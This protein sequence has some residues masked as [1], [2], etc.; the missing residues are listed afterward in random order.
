MTIF[1]KIRVDEIDSAVLIEN[2]EGYGRRI[3]NRFASAVSFCISGQITYHH[4]G[5]DYVS[6]PGTVIFLP[7]GESYTITCEKSGVFPVIN[8]TATLPF[9]NDTIYCMPLR[10]PEYFLLSFNK[11][12]S[13]FA[14]PDSGREVHAF[15][16]LYDILSH[17]ISDLEDKGNAVLAPAIKYLEDNFCDPDLNNSQL[18]DCCHISEVYFR[19]IFTAA[20]GIPP[21]KYISELRIQRAKELLKNNRLSI[22]QVSDSCGY[23]SVYHFCRAFK[24]AV[25]EAPGKY[26]RNSAMW[27]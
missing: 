9:K 25:G 6:K 10:N 7:Q 17:I 24:A 4:K 22:S 5:K 2:T 1:E 12:R 15:A 3:S 18:A 23:S 13:T 14:L 11:L 19:R 26:R 20:Y 27:F 16:Q 8:F 21:H